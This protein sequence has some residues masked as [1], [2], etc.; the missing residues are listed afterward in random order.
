MPKPRIV[1][2]ED[3]GL[4]ADGIRALIG[5]EFELIAVVTNG[6]DLIERCETLG[7][8]VALADI[9]MPVMNGLDALREIKKRGLRTKVIVVTGAADVG[10]ATEAFRA[11]ACGY[12]LKQA[13]S[14]ELMTALREASQGRTFITPRIANDVLQRL[15]EGGDD[16]EGADLTARE[17]QVLQLV[18]EGNSSKEAAAILDVTP[19]TIEFHKRNVMEKTGLRTTAELARFAAKIGLVADPMSHAR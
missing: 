8:E 9:S 2:A 14:D 7:P 1:L 15:M 12:V 3:H 16:E 4:V 19:R 10:L 11:G 5:D 18:A 6:L 13:A 17:R